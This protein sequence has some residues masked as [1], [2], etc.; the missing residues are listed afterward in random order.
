MESFIFMNASIVVAPSALKNEL[1]LAIK[2]VNNILLGKEHAVRMSFACILADGHLLIEDLPGLGKTT[3][4]QAL[5]VTLGLKYQ[6]VQFTSDLL[7]SDIVG[8]S[9]YQRDNGSFRFHPGPIFAQLLMA[10]EINRATPKTQSALLEAMAEYQVTVDAISHPLPKP[11][12]VVATQNPVDLAGTFPLPDSQLD[13]FLM[14]IELGYPDAKAEREMLVA[15][16]RRDMMA[17]LAP[18]LN[19][20]KLLQLRAQAQAV[21]AAP[22]LVDY[23]HSIVTHTRRDAMLDVGL[24]PRAGLALLHAAKAWAYLQDRDYVVPDDVQAVF[25]AVAA[26]RLVPRSDANMSRDRVALQILEKTPIN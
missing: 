18:Q 1:N 26:H 14:R 15:Q 17:Q 3:L 6:R 25:V 20:E 23:V 13:R 2:Q 11:F 16:D 4:A 12:F 5:A 19:A 7:P 8:I 9:V 10:D 22:A 21:R 24:S